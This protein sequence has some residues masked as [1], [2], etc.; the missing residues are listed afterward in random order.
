MGFSGI[1]ELPV[2]Q[3]N[4]VFDGQTNVS[5]NWRYGDGRAEILQ[6]YEKG[7]AKQWN[8]TERSDWSI[9]VDPDNP[10]GLADQSI[11]IY[12]T[13][14]WERLPESKRRE[15]RKHVQAFQ[16]SQ[17][18][19]G[20]QGALIATSK[21]VQSAPSIDEKFFA[22]TQAIDEA[23]HVEVFS[24]L[25]RDK[26][27]VAYPISEQLK[28]LLENGLSDRRWDMTYLTMQVLI[29]GLAL[30]AFQ[31]YRDYGLSQLPSSIMAYVMQDEA[32][33]VA[34]GRIA[35]RQYYPQLSEKE[36]D[37][38]EEFAVEACHLMLERYQPKGFW[39]DLDLPEQECAEA[40]TSSGLQQNFRERIFS[41]VVPT[42]KDIGLCGKRIRGAYED[43]GVLHFCDVDAGEILANDE[44]VAEQFDALRLAQDSK[45]I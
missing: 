42:M 20:E 21:L 11:P 4:W 36:R 15:V 7:K 28:K 39:Q 6:L 22:A 17:F 43:M 41:R 23:R 34:F 18:L 40:I 27:K 26:I 37:E 30:A 2:E 8:A 1:Y 3:S 31:R 9:E 14:V 45:G 24:R 13:R 33:H 44:K 29:E 38:R 12:G 19:H 10:M 32:R 35:L 5:M 25:L 16:I